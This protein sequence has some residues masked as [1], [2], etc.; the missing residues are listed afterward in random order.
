M[1]DSLLSNLGYFNSL[2]FLAAYYAGDPIVLSSILSYERSWRSLIEEVT[3]L[4]RLSEF[5]SQYFGV[6][7]LDNLKRDENLTQHHLQSP[8]LLLKNLTAPFPHPNIID[9]KMGTQT[10]EPTAPPS[11]QIREAKK[12]PPQSEIG[13]RIVGMRVMHNNNSPP[14]AGGGDEYTCWGKSFGFNLNT[15][16]E[17]MRALMT[18]FHCDGGGGRSSSHYTQ[19]I[20]SCV[21]RQLTRIKKWF[22][23]ENDTLTFYASSILVVHDGCQNLCDHIE[24][25][26]GAS[27][28]RQEP[29]VKMI[30]F[31]HVCRESGGD[32]GYLKGVTNLLN[33]LEKI[34]NLEFR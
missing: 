11:K 3:A 33:I 22:E 24:L 10:Y 9:I 7:D 20:L 32:K 2:S 16:E 23:A 18:F 28:V 19:H 13:F 5:T 15:N 8:H 27:S 21:I 34:H 26:D 4:K 30:D 12:Y 6:V 1:N 25:G 31:A 17:V 29:I 14:S